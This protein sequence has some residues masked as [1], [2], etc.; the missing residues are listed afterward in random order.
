[1]FSLLGC[2]VIVFFV[3]ACCCCGRNRRNRSSRA[4]A[5]TDRARQHAEAQETQTEAQSAVF[6]FSVCSICFCS[7]PS[8]HPETQS[9][10]YSNCSICF[11]SICFSRYP[12]PQSEA[13]TAAK[14]N[15][16]LSNHP[17]GRQAHRIATSARGL[18]WTTAP[19]RSCKPRRSFRA[20]HPPPPL[21]RP[22]K[23]TFSSRVSVARCACGCVGFY[24]RSFCSS[25]FRVRFVSLG[26]FACLHFLFSLVSFVWVH[27]TSWIRLFAFI[28]SVRSF[29]CFSER[30]FVFQ[31]LFGFVCVLSGGRL[32]ALYLREVRARLL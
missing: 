3:E 17:P 23:P 19:L 27:V 21:P 14:E 13:Q 28:F 10:V 4:K 32:H 31:R 7:I 6:S 20:A 12:E 30:S 29:V 11:C 5:S 18:C 16:R 25:F 22:R 26:P 8:R 1:M 15:A 2:P 24:L 9:A